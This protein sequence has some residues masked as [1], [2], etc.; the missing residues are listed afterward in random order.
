MRFLRT[1][2]LLLIF[3]V[4]LL[5]CRTQSTLPYYLENIVDTS[6]VDEVNIPELKIQKNDILSIQIYSQSTL[7]E[8]DEF[9]NM[10]LS[11][12]GAAGGDISLSGY[13]VDVNGNLEYPRLGTIHAEGLT[14]TQLAA[15]IK[16]RLTEPV[17][18]LKSPTVIIRY[19]NYKIMVIGEVGSPGPINVEGE[20]MTILEAIGSS[21]G[22]TTGGKKDYVKV[23]RETNG[24]REIGII[25]LSS[26]D[27]FQSPYYNLVQNDIVIVEPTKRKQ[28]TEDQSVVSQRI[29]FALG[30]ITAA[31]FIYNIFSAR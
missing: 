23:L 25:D 21:G 17:E 11:Q 3:P 2:F 22:I 26:K 1:A 14:K 24:K 31:A 6:R 15:E 13:L 27:L 16:R 5:S 18:L 10:R 9:Y 29:S 7:P 30:I 8:A 28:R 20:R 4:Y 19:L 12:G